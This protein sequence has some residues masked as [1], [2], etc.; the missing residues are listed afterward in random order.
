METEK[1]KILV[2]DDELDVVDFLKY[3]LVN[4]GYQVKTARD[5]TTAIEVAFSFKPDIILLDI[6]MPGMDG[7]EVCRRLREN[8]QF[9]RSIIIFLTARNEDYSEIASFEAGA[10][11][12]INKPIR[13]RVLKA[14]IKAI[15]SRYNRAEEKKEKKTI[16]TG[17]L[18]IDHEKKNVL[19]NGKEI[20]LPRKDFEI[21]C[22]LASRP[23]K[24]FTRDEIF[25]KVWGDDVIVTDRT[26]DVHIR[27]L[28]EKI[29]NSM[30]KTFK[31]I[32]YGLK[33]N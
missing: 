18:T 29:G 7:I 21:L 2:V 1:F 22:L 28:R 13:P 3:N 24:I 5:G 16:V 33:I 10:D 14:R 15:L 30:I 6:M 19:L 11:D 9:D 20:D 4:E 23:G 8:P 12:F 25:Q 17:Q 32:G 27:K 26:L 31:G